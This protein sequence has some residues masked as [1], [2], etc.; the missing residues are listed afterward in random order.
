ME[1][2][3]PV[4]KGDFNISSNKTFIK[5]LKPSNSLSDL[6]EDQF[7]YIS[8][9]NLHD[10]NLNIV[11]KANFAQPIVKRLNDRYNIKLKMDF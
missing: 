5:D 2:N 4:D 10:E 11:A 7:V 8:G 9:V 3:I 6:E 1:L